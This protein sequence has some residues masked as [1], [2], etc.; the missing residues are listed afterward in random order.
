[1]SV[2]MPTSGPFFQRQISVCVR[3][4]LEDVARMS[5]CFQRRSEAAHTSVPLLSLFSRFVS[6]VPLELLN[7]F[8]VNP[9][10]VDV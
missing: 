7:H 10:T 3:C 6:P 5:S 1:M 9:E 2:T 4:T 8:V